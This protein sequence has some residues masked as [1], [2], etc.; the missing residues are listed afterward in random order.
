MFYFKTNISERY[1][2]GES[3][4]QIAESEDCDY[5][6]A[7]RALKRKGIKIKRGHRFKTDIIQRFISGENIKKIAESEG[8]HPNTIR[9]ALRKK[10]ISLRM[11]K[12]ARGRIQIINGKEHKRCSICRKVLS[13]DFFRKNKQATT[14]YSSCCK[15]CKAEVYDKK[16]YIKDRSSLEK[17]FENLKPIH[18]Y[19]SKFGYRYVQFERGASYPEHRWIMMKKL[20][21]PLEKWEWVHHK[22]RNK[23]DNRLENLELSPPTHPEHNFEDHKKVSMTI[24]KKENEKLKER[25]KE[26]EKRTK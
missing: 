7:R 12:Q 25:I 26:L 23:L 21:R 14:G 16:R 3:I 17:N 20:G 24:L 5:N 22:N 2:N 1:L 9:K 19:I 8:C 6:T 10:G 13:I 18:T 4:R 15:I 11:G